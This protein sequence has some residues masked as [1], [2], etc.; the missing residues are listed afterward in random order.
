MS[1]STAVSKPPIFAGEDERELKLAFAFLLMLHSGN[2]AEA[3][4]EQFPGE[5]NYGRAWGVAEH[6][7][8]DPIVASEV[9]RLEREG[10]IELADMMKAED[11]YAKEAYDRSKSEPDAK[12]RLEYFKLYGEVRGYVGK[13]S[14]TQVQV[15]VV[16]NVIEVPTRVS[17]EE[18]PFLEGQWAEQQ[19]QLMADARSSRPS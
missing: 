7:P 17:D 3:A 6:W 4:Y 13:G 12:L 9:A 8:H 18:L 5:Q 11:A 2:A 15:N 10:S 19:K 16:Q 1:W 14:G